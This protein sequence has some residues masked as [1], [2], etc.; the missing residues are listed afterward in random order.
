MVPFYSVMHWV[1]LKSTESLQSVRSIHMNKE[2]IEPTGILGHLKCTGLAVQY[3]RYL[4]VH[5]LTA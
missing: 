2:T 4:S 3:A 1:A 5:V